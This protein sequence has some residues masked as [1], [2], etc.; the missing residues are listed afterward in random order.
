MMSGS[1]RIL[2][3]QGLLTVFLAGYVGVAG[4]AHSLLSAAQVKDLAEAAAEASSIDMKPFSPAVPHFDPLTR[5]WLI[6]FT[7][8]DQGSAL[9]RKLS[10]FVYDATSRAEVTCMGL[11]SFGQSMATA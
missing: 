9:L 5:V 11:T 3:R 2:M 8:N 4:A 7:A 10:V 6:N 1:L